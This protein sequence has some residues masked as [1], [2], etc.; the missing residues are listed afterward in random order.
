MARATSSQA[1]KPK[2]KWTEQM[3]KDVLECKKKAQELVVSENPPC[4]ENE[5][6]RGYIRDLPQNTATATGMLPNKRFNEQN[7]GCAC[8]F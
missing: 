6:R 1:R 5:R 8:T 3:N 7:N 4:N 2:V